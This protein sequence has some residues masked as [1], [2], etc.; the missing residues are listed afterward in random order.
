MLIRICHAK[1][2]AA[3]KAQQVRP[4]AGS[5]P[6]D[7]TQGS[8]AEAQRALAL[9]KL[10][11]LAAAPDRLTPQ[12]L[13][14]AS[15]LVGDL[16]TRLALL[17]LQVIP[18]DCLSSPATCAPSPPVPAGDFATL[19]SLPRHLR[20]LP[21]PAHFRVLAWVH[22]AGAPGFADKMLLSCASSWLRGMSET[23]SGSVTV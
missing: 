22:L 7:M 6:I 14:E 18:R 21:S 8:V 9:A 20:P 11:A 15:A 13:P 23:Q 16:D 5:P 19:T 10:S 12:L 17:S 4:Q 1:Q 2:A 3:V